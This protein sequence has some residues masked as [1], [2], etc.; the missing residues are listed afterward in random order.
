MMGAMADISGSC[1]KRFDR[2]TDALAACFDQHGDV[3]ASA[4]VVYKD[5]VVVDLW[6]GHL[7][8]ARTKPWERD[9][10]INVW[11]TTKTMS[12]LSLLVLAS[13]TQDTE[14]LQ[15]VTE[16]L[17]I[18]K[19]SWEMLVRREVSESYS[20]PPSDEGSYSGFDFSA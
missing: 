17:E 19:D 18:E 3:G 2:V 9:T 16:I 15:N 13:Q 7:D 11:S 10:I 6:G 1:D 4:A 8:V 20:P 14:T 5:E 12:C